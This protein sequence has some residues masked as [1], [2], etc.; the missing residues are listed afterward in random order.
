MRKLIINNLYEREVNCFN[1]NKTILQHIH[2]EGIDWM[3]ACGAKGRC[4]TCRMIVQE[5]MEHLSNPSEAELRYRNAG[6]LQI[7]ERLCCQTTFVAEGSVRAEIPQ[8]SKFPHMKYS[9]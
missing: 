8:N 7:N 6:R 5:G 2:D 4:T 1:P 9:D 3:F